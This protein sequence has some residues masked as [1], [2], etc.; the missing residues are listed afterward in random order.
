MLILQQH[1]LALSISDGVIYGYSGMPGFE[2]LDVLSEVSFA[3]FEFMSQ[4]FN[5]F[6]L[7]FLQLDCTK[8]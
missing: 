5:R 2:E 6:I 4:N 1:V 3:A 7:Y 8:K